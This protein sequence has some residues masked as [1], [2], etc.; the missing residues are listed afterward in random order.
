MSEIVGVP[1]VQSVAL[2]ELKGL[3]T[4]P[5]G[6]ETSESGLG[7][8]IETHKIVKTFK[9]AAGE[10]TVLKGIDLVIERGEF[11]SI[12]G[13]SGSGKSTLLN[14]I[15]GI[16]HPTSGQMIVGGTDIYHNMTE[17]ARSRW[18]GKNLGIVF[19]FFQLLPML[20]LL[21][22][23]MLPMDYA[24][25]Y[26]FEERPARAKELLE[27]VGLEKEASKL[28]AA[29]STGQ[30]QAAAIARA[31]ACDPPLLVADEPTGN[32][33]SK[34]ANK[35]I[36]VFE[37]LVN[38]GKTIVMVTHDP[39]L[40]SRTD[41]NII[42]SDGELIDEAVSRAL[43]WLRHRHMLEITK[44]A[45]RVVYQPGEV[46]LDCGR[47]VESLFIVKSGS[48]EVTKVGARGETRLSELDECEFF[49]EIELLRGG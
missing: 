14:M 18:R 49:G 35:I 6:Q 1:G 40:T 21:E 27:L 4:L 23:V 41:R 2:S 10:F 36:E 5:R 7:Y 30:Q 15:T 17:S 31:M 29:V 37:K 46:I 19:Q 12:V 34:S 45:K 47:P 33:D 26:E 44:N 13:K 11:V 20:T 28:P 9:N 8:M 25:M 22:N 43:P 39:S 24:D 48:V 3:Q 38:Q 16:D 32:L 42:I